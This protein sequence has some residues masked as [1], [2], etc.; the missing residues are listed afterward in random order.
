M[1]RYGMYARILCVHMRIRA[2]LL[3]S[4]ACL[5]AGKTITI[6]LAGTTTVQLLA[7]VFKYQVYEDYV[8]V[9]T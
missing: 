2:C 3:P 5:A 7:G 4:T 9:S 8:P 1:F 6:E